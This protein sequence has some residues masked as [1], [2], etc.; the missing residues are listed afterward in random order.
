MYPSYCLKKISPLS[1]TDSDKN[2]SKWLVTK[3]RI[4]SR[5]LK[6]K[7]NFFAKVRPMNLLNSHQNFN[8]ICETSSHRFDKKVAQ[9]L[10][11]YE[12]NELFYTYPLITN[13]TIDLLIW[14]FFHLMWTFFEYSHAKNFLIWPHNFRVISFLKWATNLW[15]RVYTE[16]VDILDKLVVIFY[17]LFW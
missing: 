14:F 16:T 5:G 12:K 11:F 17:K 8:A 7:C 4:Y 15:S 13:G 1:H 6:Q 2:T 9:C 3:S 10:F